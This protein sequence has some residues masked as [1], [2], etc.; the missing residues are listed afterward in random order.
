M[1]LKNLV[2]IG[3]NKQDDIIS[4]GGNAGFLGLI[5][6]R[7]LSRKLPDVAKQGDFPKQF[8][9]R[10]KKHKHKKTGSLMRR[11]KYEQTKFREEQIDLAG[12]EAGKVNDY[13]FRGKGA[14]KYNPFA[15]AAGNISQSGGY[16]K[17]GDEEFRHKKDKDEII[18]PH[19]ELGKRVGKSNLPD[20]IKQPD[21]FPAQLQPDSKIKKPRG[22]VIKSSA[23]YSKPCI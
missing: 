12:L 19:F 11:T 7:S 10:A 3:T 22:F 21:P 5:Q 1:R 2:R 23:K 17:G 16:N 4:K 6:D 20:G 9:V 18:K 13:V 14:M 8:D 15:G